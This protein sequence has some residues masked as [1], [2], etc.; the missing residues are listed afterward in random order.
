MIKEKF[1][2]Y[3]LFPVSM[4]L[5]QLVPFFI[6]EYSVSSENF[7]FFLLRHV[8]PLQGGDREID[9]STAAVARQRPAKNR[10]IVFSAWSAKQHLNSNRGTAFSV[11]RAQDRAVAD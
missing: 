3:F 8:D 1:Y 10:G 5:A 4:L 7:L 2:A 9:D 11:V 6:M